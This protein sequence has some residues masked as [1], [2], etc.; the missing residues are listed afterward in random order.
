MC[1][2]QWPQTF[3]K[4]LRKNICR[5]DAFI[6]SD[7]ISPGK[8][9]VTGYDIRFHEPIKKHINDWNERMSKSTMEELRNIWK[10]I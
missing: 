4:V 9:R 8:V 1:P 5:N 10:Q 2:M 6:R 3:G 7:E